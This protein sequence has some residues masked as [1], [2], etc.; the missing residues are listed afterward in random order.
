MVRFTTSPD[1]LRASHIPRASPSPS[2]MMSIQERA[3]FQGRVTYEANRANKAEQRA[4]NE[5]KR[6]NDYKLL[7][8]KEAKR[9]DEWKVQADKESLRADDAMERANKEHQQVETLYESIAELFLEN[10]TLK[11]T[12]KKLQTTHPK[13]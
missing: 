7:A 8:A 6:A 11:S 2:K 1:N 9:A 12:I 10:M 5:S 4:L 13:P 3:F